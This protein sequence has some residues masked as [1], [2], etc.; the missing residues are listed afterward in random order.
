[1]KRGGRGNGAYSTVNDS[2]AGERRLM[3]KLILSFPSSGIG[4]TMV[5]IYNTVVDAKRW[6]LIFG[7][8]SNGREIISVY[9]M[10]F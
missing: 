8:N 2:F 4:L 5:S 6:S 10:R 1:M 7:L 9:P 3:K